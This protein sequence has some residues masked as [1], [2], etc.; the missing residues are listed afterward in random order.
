MN[1]THAATET[2]ANAIMEEIARA[3]KSGATVELLSILPITNCPE[4]DIAD[5][6]GSPVAASDMEPIVV[7]GLCVSGT[8]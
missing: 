1:D 6:M 2:I 7:F 4:Y 8:T 5:G 3:E